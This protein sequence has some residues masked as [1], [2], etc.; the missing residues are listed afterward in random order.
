MNASIEIVSQPANLAESLAKIHAATM[1]PGKPWS[2][3]SFAAQCRQPGVFAVIC[4]DSPTLPSPA[5]GEEGPPL[6]EGEGRGEGN[7]FILCR[8]AADE[9]EILTFAVIPAAQ[10]RGIG[11]KL[12]DAALCQAGAQGCTATFLEVAADN[13]AAL[14]IY[15]KAGFHEISCRKAYYGGKTDAVV[16]RKNIDQPF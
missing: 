15:E 4:A 10:G 12:L 8:I 11:Q 16:M 3:E 1:P 9:C 2:E 7:G 13:A 14:H 5:S 6:P